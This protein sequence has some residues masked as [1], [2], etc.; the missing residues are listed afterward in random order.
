MT[1]HTIQAAMD[2]GELSEEEAYFVLRFA[3]RI[4]YSKTMR[5][6]RHPIKRIREWLI[7][8]GYETPELCQWDLG[9]PAWKWEKGPF[10]L[11][12]LGSRVVINGPD[13]NKWIEFRVNGGRFMIS[14]NR[15]WDHNE[16]EKT[17]WS[18]YWSANGT[19]WDKRSVW[20]Y[21]G[22]RK[23]FFQPPPDQH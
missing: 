16:K 9:W 22:L 4:G 20:F 5:R 18:V 1:P 23:R 14:W 12:F 21:D 17:W 3:G 2:R 11:S 15:T 6:L 10:P 19:P 13:N 7:R 8:T